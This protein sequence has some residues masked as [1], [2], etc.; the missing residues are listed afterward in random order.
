MTSDIRC[1]R[2]GPNRG[3][4]AGRRAWP[5]VAIG[6]NPEFIGLVIAAQV[7]LEFGVCDIDG[8]Q[9]IPLT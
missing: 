4:D 2:P 5:D 8:R 7:A 6:Q 9:P 3:R 1:T